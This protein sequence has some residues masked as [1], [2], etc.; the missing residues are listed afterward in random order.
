MYNVDDVPPLLPTNVRSIGRRTSG[1]E[2]RVRVNQLPRV[3]LAYDR[4][5]S[6][7][8]GAML[9]SACH[10]VGGKH[11]W[12]V[13]KFLALETAVTV[14]FD[15]RRYLAQTFPLVPEFEQHVRLSVVENGQVLNHCFVLFARTVWKA[16]SCDSEVLAILR[17][18]NGIP[19][20]ISV[21]LG[22]L[23]H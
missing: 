5:L 3:V 12:I 10:A 6:S 4:A 2:R 21:A 16:W 23:D 14:G 17:R 11:Y 1:Y 18:Y 8:V 7:M 22:I 20:V 19:V 15:D 13:D 9:L